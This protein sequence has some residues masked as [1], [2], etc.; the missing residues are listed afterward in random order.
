[1][2]NPPPDIFDASLVDGD[3]WQKPRTIS[4]YRAATHEKLDLLYWKNGAIVDGAYDRLCTILRDVQAGKTIRMDPKLIET[5]WACQAFCARY[6][7]H[8]PLTVLSG[9]RTPATNRKL[10]E[11]GLPAAR[12]SLHL[13]GQAADVRIVDLDPEV[14]GGLVKSFERGGVGFYFRPG[15]AMGGWIH[16]DTGV[17]R[18]WRG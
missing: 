13:D 3:F 7:I 8:H 12:K 14:L 9:Y 17:N 15:G 11:E 16:T 6:G 1:M 18:V 5:L 2:P 4:L 10:I